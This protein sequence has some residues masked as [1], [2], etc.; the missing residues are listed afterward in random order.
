MYKNGLHP[1][2]IILNHILFSLFLKAQFLLFIKF[3]LRTL[4]LF[5]ENIAE[6]GRGLVF[7][8]TTARYSFLYLEP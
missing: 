1:A 7:T 3:E 4:Y 8:D 6:S 5:Q 2:K